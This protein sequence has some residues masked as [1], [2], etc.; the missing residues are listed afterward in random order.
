M[1]TWHLRTELHAGP[2]ALLRLRGFRLPKDIFLPTRAVA[3]DGQE[4]L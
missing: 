4:R 2:L 1:L 3:D